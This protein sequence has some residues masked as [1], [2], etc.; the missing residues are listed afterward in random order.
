MVAAKIL[1][2]PESLNIES[3]EDLEKRERELQEYLTDD[4]KKAGLQVIVR[5][6]VSFPLKYVQDVLQLKH[7]RE[8]EV[9]AA[10]E[11]RD[12][13]GLVAGPKNRKIRTITGIN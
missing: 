2:H 9:A 1:E 3:V 4:Q 12:T 7:L 8:A 5:P 11:R 13:S 6:V 10:A